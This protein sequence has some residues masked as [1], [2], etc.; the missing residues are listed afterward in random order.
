[1]DVQ[2]KE[3]LLVYDNLLWVCKNNSTSIHHWLFSFNRAPCPVLWCN[4]HFLTMNNM[5]LIVIKKSFFFFFFLK[6]KNIYIQIYKWLKI[7][8]SPFLIFSQRYEHFCN[9]KPDQQSLFSWSMLN[10]PD[11]LLFVILC[12]STVAEDYTQV[13]VCVCDIGE[14]FGWDQTACR[15]TTMLGFVPSLENLLSFNYP[16]SHWGNKRCLSDKC[17]LRNTSSINNSTLQ[18]GMYRC[19]GGGW[20]SKG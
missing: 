6:R 8:F 9:R 7:Y 14:C 12:C 11:K 5:V 3:V 1:M 20:F 4:I 17:F 15:R 13:C 19:M 16:A 2:L 10:V 18:S